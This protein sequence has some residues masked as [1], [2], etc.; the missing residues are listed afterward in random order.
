MIPNF[1]FEK[2]SKTVQDKQMMDN[3]N[4]GLYYNASYEIENFLSVQKVTDS[5]NTS[6]IY[7][8]LSDP[9]LTGFKMFF[10]FADNSGLLANE[11]YMNSALAYLDRIG[12]T[13]RYDL[14]KRFI[15]ALSDVSS[16]CPWI[17][18]EIS[19]LKEIFERSR[20]MVLHTD[21]KIEIK[22]LET[23]DGKIGSLVKM[24]R[25]IVFDE[26]RKVWVIPENLRKFS[27]SV[28]VY[29]YR[30][31]NPNPSL[32]DEV[33]VTSEFLLTIDNTDIKKLNHTLFELSNCMFD[34]ASGGTFFTNV[35]NN[36]SEYVGNNLIINTQDCFISS[37]FRTIT[38]NVELNP[39]TVELAKVGSSVGT[40]STRKSKDWGLTDMDA[41]LGRLKDT[42]LFKG[43]MDKKDELKNFLDVQYLKNAGMSILREGENR[44][45]DR[46]ESKL[47]QMY[48]GNVHGF[49]MDDILRL[50]QGNSYKSAFVNASSTLNGNQSLKNSNPYRDDLG[51]IN[52]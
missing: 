31:F 47:S 30:M 9:T 6:S 42:Q 15:S 36:Q 18:Q 27:M 49:G 13:Q 29:D 38:G 35:S 33:S 40:G 50:N 39:Q 52:N 12:E 28:Y 34:D 24:Y 8:A 51:N 5:E 37:L 19:G 26:V 46:I 1:D 14:L 21:S 22:T 48:F 20:S 44:L 17:F 4:K 45:L 25:D 2:L 11:S 7:S 32:S 41:R 43:V 3:R 10:H 23:I 16:I